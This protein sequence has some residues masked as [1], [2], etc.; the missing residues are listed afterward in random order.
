MPL[1]LVHHS[2]SG[3][4]SHHRAIKVKVSHLLLKATALQI[5]NLYKFQTY[6]YIPHI[7]G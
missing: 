4:Q 1:K 6:N 2:C 5:C 3:T 7:R